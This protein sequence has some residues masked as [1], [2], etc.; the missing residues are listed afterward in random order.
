MTDPQPATTA[1][2]ATALRARLDPATLGFETTATL[3]PL[4]HLIGQDRAVEAIL[5]SAGIGHKR[6]NLFVHGPEGTGRHSA[7]MDLLTQEAARR[8]A[9]TDWV[10]VHNF[11]APERPRAL[12][13]P[14]GAGQRLKLAMQE[15]VDDLAND[16]PALFESEDYQRR[17]AAIEEQFGGQQEAAFAALG[18]TA[19]DRG[20]AILRTPMGFALAPMKDGEV[21]KPETIARLPEAEQADIQAKVAATERDLEAFLK[22]VPRLQKDHRAAVARLNA[23][24]AQNAVEAGL[25]RVIEA[26]RGVAV[27]EDYFADLHRDL[28]DNAELFLQAGQREGD[29]AFPMA[30]VR[31]QDDLRFH[32]YAVNVMICRPADITE[33][34]PVVHE[35]LPTLS[36]LTGRIDH[37]STM[38]T[39]VTDFTLI[40]PGAL[41]RA[42]GGFLVL[43]AARVLAEPL[44][45]DALKRCLETRAIHV[46]TAAERL[47]LTTTTTLE[48]DPIPLD[49]RVVLVGDRRLLRL[50]EA[51]DPDFGEL[52]GVAAEFSDEMDRTPAAIDA[53]A[54][55]VASVAARE[56]LR[57]VTAGGVAA[58]VDAAS[59]HAGDQRKLS[60]RVNAIWDILREADHLAARGG[61]ATVTEAEVTGAE[62]AAERRADLV[63]ERMQEMIARGTILISTRGSV[64]GQ[65]NG[66]TVAQLGARAFGW[67]ARITARVR[68][69]AGQVVDIEREVKMGG[70]IH[71]K[72]VMILTAFLV[73]RYAPDM[74]LSL[75][76]SLGF[77]QSYGGVEGDSASV[78]EL[79]ALLSA[80]AQV[81]LSQALAVTGSI[82]QMGEVQP[83]GGIN[84]KIEGFFDTCRAQGLTGRQGV[85]IPR[86]NVENLMLRADVVAAV[87]E[88]QFHIHAIGHVDQAIALLT[89]LPA[90]RRGLNG[91]FEPGSV[92]ANVEVRLMDFAEARRDFAR[93]DPTGPAAA[94]RDE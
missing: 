18:R 11:D 13:L 70:P 69:G 40:R 93:H 21:L 6:F 30:A 87:A 85:L 9:P 39:L 2:P 75:W 88:G 37:I 16:I 48:P 74:P 3:A 77:E 73:T 8:P 15:L 38:G 86:Q 54:R 10:Y 23:D 66:L 35:T 45:W 46:I 80:L 76:A 94:D 78:A 36:N 58:L 34:A 32:R 12:H 47:G 51:F 68:M 20:V 71:S 57:P 64:M 90:G 26:F 67:P 25:D 22:S 59:R 72:A 19:H 56:G 27:L 53:F 92:N 65:V 55:L 79:C 52:F 17:R 81:P 7:V 89:G 33:G 50:L 61:A 84:E 28:I 29:G 14:R 49:L 31:L 83:V 4:D 91:D 5:L 44:A 60:L 42:N 43:D 82:N 62:A 1:L 63:R 41:H 24:M